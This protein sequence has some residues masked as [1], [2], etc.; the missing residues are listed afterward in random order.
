MSAAVISI[1]AAGAFFLFGLI[2]GVIKYQQIM[3]SPQGR[4]HIYMDTCHRASLM[5]AFACLLIYQFV[6]I[7]QL[8]DWLEM[9]SVVLLVGYFATAVI[10]YFVHGI[11]QDTRNQL[12][13]PE[14]DQ[15]TPVQRMIPLYMWTLIAAEI[16]GFLVLFYGV[17]IELA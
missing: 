13:L 14:K 9:V 11:K 7:S 16:G 5:Y 6:L 17:I 12:Q 4:A 10:S 1:L 8:P 2:T 15:Q 3:A